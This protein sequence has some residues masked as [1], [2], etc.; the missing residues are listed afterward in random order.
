MSRARTACLASLS[1][2]SNRTI[3]CPVLVYRPT[4]TDRYA[5]AQL[6][7]F[8]EPCD[9]YG[10][11]VPTTVYSKPASYQTDCSTHG[12]WG[13]APLFCMGGT[14]I[15]G[16]VVLLRHAGTHALYV[17][18]GGTFSQWNTPKQMTVRRTVRRAHTRGDSADEFPGDG[19][20]IGRA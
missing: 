9:V 15:T 11:G 4:K 20:P 14:R 5:T 3:Q 16:F 7:E 2:P 19:R 6:E 8:Q 18:H 13:R 12:T 17:D 1:G 10:R